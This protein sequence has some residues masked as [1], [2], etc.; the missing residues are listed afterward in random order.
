MSSVVRSVSQI[1][2]RTKFLIASSAT[3]FFLA[4]APIS[5]IMNESDFLAFT[6]ENSSA[7]GSLFRDLG[8]SVTTINNSGIHTQTF[9]LVQQQAGRISEGVDLNTA[10]FYVRVWSADTVLNPI[11]VVRVG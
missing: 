1:D 5:A 7:S 9:R 6:N 11:D 10:P 2:N 8:K 4:T 3:T